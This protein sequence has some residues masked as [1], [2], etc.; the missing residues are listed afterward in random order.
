MMQ[1]WDAR[2]DLERFNAEVFLPAMARVGARGFPQPPQVR[3][4]NTVRAWIG[5]EEL[6]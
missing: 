6:P 2:S 1:L 3:D 4:V 5:S